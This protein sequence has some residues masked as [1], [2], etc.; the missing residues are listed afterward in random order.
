MF[1]LKEQRAM[2]IHHFKRL[3]L[4]LQIADLCCQTC[5]TDQCLEIN[6]EIMW[7]INANSGFRQIYLYRLEL[8]ND[9][10]AV[11]LTSPRGLP[12]DHVL[13]RVQNGR[14]GKGH[15]RK[16]MR[17]FPEVRCLLF[18]STFRTIE[19]ILCMFSKFPPLTLSNRLT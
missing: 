3:S 6:V 11:M 15:D 14:E 2:S 5:E 8:Y 16:S 13:L 12:G 4:S 10:F 17:L 7:K 9:E 19:R 18:A 1:K